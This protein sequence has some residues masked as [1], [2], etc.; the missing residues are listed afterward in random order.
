[1]TEGSKDI[2][3][4]AF[5]GPLSSGRM[6]S[7]NLAYFHWAPGKKTNTMQ[8]Q[9]EDI[10]WVMLGSVVLPRLHVCVAVQ[11]SVCMS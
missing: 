10:R 6:G 4:F 7:F 5:E 3:V 2:R 9:G 8:A 1:M 11:K